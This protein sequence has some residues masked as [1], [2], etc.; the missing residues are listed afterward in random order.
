M[1]LMGMRGAMSVAGFGRGIHGN[2][3]PAGNFGLFASAL[4]NPVARQVT[5]YSFAGDVVA[6]GTQLTTQITSSSNVGAGI[7]T[8]AI[9]AVGGGTASTEFK[10]NAYSYATN[11]TTAGG[12]LAAS[13]NAGCAGCNATSMLIST[14]GNI[15][16][17]ILYDF[18]SDTSGITTSL[19]SNA[20]AR[21]SCAGNSSYLVFALSQG[22][23]VTNKYTWSSGATALATSLTSNYSQG[24]GMSNAVEGLFFGAATTVQ[25]YIWS[26]ET[27]Q[28]GTASPIAYSSGGN[29]IGNDTRAVY[30]I[31]NNP[32]TYKYMYADDS[33]AAGGVLPQNLNGG[34]G[35]SQGITGVSV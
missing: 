6:T 19:V 13:I 1:S 18:P 25:K 28:P 11:V 30:A 35:A 26:G 34:A 3:F 24:A 32:Q 17:L 16:T 2:T 8:K 33:I 14:G 22:G 12:N 23:T 4:A 15:K 10:T 20:V 21:P 7:T 5:K 9:I 27:V 29:A 31:S